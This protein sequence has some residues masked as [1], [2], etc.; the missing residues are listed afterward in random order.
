MTLRTL[1][2]LL[3]LLGA[4]AASAATLTD[5]R[6]RHVEVGGTPQRIVSLSPALTETVCELRACERLVGTDRYSNW[7][8]RVASL[9]KLGGLEDAQIERIV[10]LR[11]DLVLTATSTRAVDRLEA[12]GL[13]VLALEPRNLPDIRRVVGLVAQALGMPA[14]GTSLWQRVEARI[15]AAAARV[16]L[17][18]RGKQVYFEVAST[19]FAAGETSS[20]RTTQSWPPRR[21]ALHSPRGER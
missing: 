5:D 21:S 2:L 17:S 13:R 7:P 14:A 15:D 11:P 1:L 10:A 3:G 18:L 19:P 9:P 12:L 8:P 16:P 6:G 20:R 4:A